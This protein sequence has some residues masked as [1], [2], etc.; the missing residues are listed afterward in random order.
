MTFAKGGK[1]TQ[2]YN[3]IGAYRDGFLLALNR[4]ANSCGS[5]P[6]YPETSQ[7][8]SRNFTKSELPMIETRD[9]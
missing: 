8:I 7:R 1:L 9:R 4:Y 2:S 5:V 6:E 3:A